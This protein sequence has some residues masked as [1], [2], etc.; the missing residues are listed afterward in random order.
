MPSNNI[1]N[2]TKIKIYL[3]VTKLVQRPEKIFLNVT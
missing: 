2:D 3:R 1:N